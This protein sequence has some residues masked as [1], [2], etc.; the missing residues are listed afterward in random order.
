MNSLLFTAAENATRSL[1]GQ[2]PAAASQ[3]AG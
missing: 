2:W 3:L 1:G